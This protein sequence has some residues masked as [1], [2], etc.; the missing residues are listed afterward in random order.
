MEDEYFSALAEMSASSDVVLVG[1]IRE[2]TPGAI[3]VGDPLDGASGQIQFMTASLTVTRVIRGEVSGPLLVDLFIPNPTQMADLI[4]RRPEG[5]AIYFLRS[6]D[7]ASATAG[8]VV[9]AGLRG[10]FRLISSQGLLRDIGGKIAIP[11]LAESAFL[12]ALDGQDFG[13]L[14]DTLS[15]G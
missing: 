11:P 1:T 5:R 9:P 13:A 3:I 12:R 14:L 6:Q 2:L 7:R 4:S 8:Q 15:R 10:H